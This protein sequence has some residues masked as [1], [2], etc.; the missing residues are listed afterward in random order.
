MLSGVHA[1]KTVLETVLPLTPI[2]RSLFHIRY[3]YFK[4]FHNLSYNNV[5]YL[6]QFLSSLV[7]SFQ[8]LHVMMSHVLHVD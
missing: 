4:T 8:V 7:A 3:N 5:S 6:S 2:I 1:G